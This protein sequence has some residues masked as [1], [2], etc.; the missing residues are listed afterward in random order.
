MKIDSVVVRYAGMPPVLPYQE[1]LK[2]MVTFVQHMKRGGMIKLLVVPGSWD[3]A[4]PSP[5]LWFQDT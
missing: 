1:T 2:K 5:A 3:S 4:G